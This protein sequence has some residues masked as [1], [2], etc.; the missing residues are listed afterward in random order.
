MRI[1]VFPLNLRSETPYLS[2]DLEPAP[3]SEQTPSPKL[4]PAISG[5]PPYVSLLGSEPFVPPQILSRSTNLPSHP[6]LSGPQPSTSEWMLTPDT[7]RYL[8]KTVEDFTGYVR[9]VVL[10]HRAS[11]A[12]AELQKQEFARQ[13]E[14]CK[15]IIGTIERLK[16]PRQVARNE[17]LQRLQQTQK[18]LV[19]RSDKVL[20]SLMQKASP[21]LSESETK[22]F[23]ELRRMKEEVVGASKYDDRSLAARARLVCTINIGIGPHCS[24]DLSA[25]QGGGPSPSTAQGAAGKGKGAEEENG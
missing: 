19:A 22:W 16:G 6:R 13:R 20:Q 9:E 1:S 4:I 3:A 7:L 12:R 18:D 2:T 8:G 15:D 25:S 14:K 23:D 5:A 17:K 24:H 10:A 11:E 21:E